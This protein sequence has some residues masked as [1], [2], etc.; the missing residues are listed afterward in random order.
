V[1]ITDVIR[2][3]ETKQGYIEND[4]HL[5]SVNLD[6]P[7]PKRIQDSIQLTNKSSRPPHFLAVGSN[8]FCMYHEDEL[9]AMS[10]VMKILKEHGNDT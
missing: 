7:L 4:W 10:L 1:K 8:V 3:P 5:Y 2:H 6:R 9:A